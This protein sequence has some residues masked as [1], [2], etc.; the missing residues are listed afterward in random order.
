MDFSRGT[1]ALALLTCAGLALA[2]DP[3]TPQAGLLVLRNGQVLAGQITRAGDFYV[4]TLGATGEVRL[5]KAEVELECASLDEAYAQ[6][7]DNIFPRGARGHLDL[8]EWCLRHRL[9]SK[10]AEQ[11][12]TAMKLEPDNPRIAELDRRFALAAQGPPPTVAKAPAT[13]ATV[14]VEQLETTLRGLPAGS[15]EKFSAV[16]Q[17]ILLNRCGANQCHGPN[18][19]TAFTLLK[20]PP[21]ASSTQRFMQRNLYAALQQIDTSRPEA[22]PLVTM[23][24]RRH[25]SALAA[26]FDKHSQKQLDELTSWVKLSFVRPATVPATIPTTSGATLSQAAPTQQPAVAND[27]GANAGSTSSAAATALKPASPGQFVPRD[28]FD[29]EIF[30]RRY[31]SHGERPAPQHSIRGLD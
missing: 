6:K 4:V 9:L 21:G 15:I 23:P 11:L 2:A 10:G 1:A 17:P 3:L 28:A 27:Q 12:V 14:S 30:N 13:A 18:A 25:G 5:P 16:V 31:I 19:K 20:P 22:S 26:V 8:A 24:Q 7:C 29:P